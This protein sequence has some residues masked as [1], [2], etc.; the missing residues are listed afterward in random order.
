MVGTVVVQQA[1]AP[2]PATQEQIDAANATQIQADLHSGAA[3]RA[4]ARE[5]ARRLGTGRH[6]VVIVGAMNDRA[7]LMRFVGP[8]N[9]VNVGD[10]VTFRAVSMGE[11]HTVTF[12]N[13]L[14][15][16]GTPPCNPE[17]QWN[18]T[19]TPHGNRFARYPAR[20][21]EFTGGRHSLNSGLMLGLPPAL[22]HLPKSLT[23]KFTKTGDFNY[24]CALHAYFGM[25]GA[26]HV[27][28]R[29]HHHKHH[30]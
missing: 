3:L 17:Q 29:A 2:Y 10:K 15:G 23:V 24:I 7:M 18:T 1:G 28:P 25:V 26:V 8:A 30:H 22:T 16:C 6:P 9:K 19:Q 21:G 4:Q 5:Q 12:G 13:P 27:H 20:N 14:T 11:P